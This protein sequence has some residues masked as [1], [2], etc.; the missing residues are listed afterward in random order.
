MQL[1]LPID[2][3]TRRLSQIHRRLLA[4]FGRPGPW[5]P[6][7]PVSQLVMGIIGGRTRGED[8]LAA[9][10]ALLARF[11]RWE[12]VRDASL[13]EVRCRI[14]AVTFADVKAARL[15]AAL[16]TITAARGR[17]TLDFL[18]GLTVDEGLFWLERLPGVGRKVAAATLNFSSLRK[19]A[20][21]IDTHHLRVLRRLGLVGPRTSPLQAYD[22]L[23]PCL[24]LGWT[25]E[26]LDDHHQLMKALGQTT[27]R[28][29]VPS[30]HLCPLRALCPGGANRLL[31]TSPAAGASGRRIDS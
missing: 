26:D 8:S 22:A 17:L 24:P 25:A 12:A 1:V 3:R 19:P 15:K 5:I 30:C 14:R 31:A 21:V 7:D 27:C 6:L 2:D 4:R 20:L 28:H 29:G 10:Q 18:D 11:G 16:R 23:M 13:S 9:F